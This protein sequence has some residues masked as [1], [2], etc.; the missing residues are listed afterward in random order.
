MLSLDVQVKRQAFD[1]SLCATF[2]GI[3]AVMGPSGSGKTT[4]LH[5]I[6]GLVKPDR[7]CVQLHHHVL[8]DTQQRVSVPIHQRGVGLV[9]QDARL[10]PH[11]TVHR[12]LVYGMP[13]QDR[14]EQP[15]ELMD[16][17]QSLGIDHLLD[18]RAATLSGGQQQR[19]AMGRAILSQP[20]VLLLD[21]PCAAL[22]HRSRARVLA[23]IQR[24]H[25]RWRIPVLMVCHH[26][27]DA[28]S[29]TSKILLI[30]EGQ[31]VAHD[32]YHALLADAAASAHLSTDGLLNVL[33]VRAKS[34]NATHSTGWFVEGA[35]RSISITGMHT[36]TAHEQATVMI[37][38]DDIALSLAPAEFVSMRNQ[39]PGTISSVHQ[40]GDRLLCLVDVGCKLIVE[41]T[42]LSFGDL[43]LAVGKRVW[44]LFKSCAVEYMASTPRASA[45]GIA[46]HTNAS[47][48]QVLGETRVPRRDRQVVRSS[49]RY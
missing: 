38:A 12:N 17:A 9:F 49:N 32:D 46:P 22:D 27:R 4:L 36:P 14:H 31:P 28:L 3:T 21:E 5:A 43:D 29:L 39:L 16:V 25:Q 10:L 37:R 1:F 24:V 6:A 18:Q 19:V 26:L 23:L 34:N 2:D 35:S 48:S 40:R 41:V 30:T 8:H 13:R 15:F 45:P 33:P 11:L 42:D 20:R 7:G 44:C 47:V